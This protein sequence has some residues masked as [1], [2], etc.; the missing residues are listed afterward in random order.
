MV[1]AVV[2]CS[3]FAIGFLPPL[4]YLPRG[5]RNLVFGI[6]VPPP[7]TS[8]E[9]LDRVGR[10]VQSGVAE[11]IGRDVGGVPA[12]SRSFFVGSPERIFA[13]AVAE[14]PERVGEMLAWLQRN[15]AEIPGFISFATQASLFGRAAG[16]R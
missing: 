1:V 13:G 9:E 2:A 3:A 8:V 12:I 15:Q 16:G 11:H 14:D 10:Q 7:G 4:E 6:L 5:N